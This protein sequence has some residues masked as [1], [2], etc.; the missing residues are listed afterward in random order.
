MARYASA[1]HSRYGGMQAAVDEAETAKQKLL[2]AIHSLESE[3]SG[4]RATTEE[5]KTYRGKWLGYKQREPEIRKFLETFA[6]VAKSVVRVILRAGNTDNVSENLRLRED[7]RLLGGEPTPI[8]TSRGAATYYDPAERRESLLPPQTPLTVHV[9]GPSATAT[10]ISLPPAT[11]LSRSGVLNVPTLSHGNGIHQ[12]HPSR[13]RK[14]EEDPHAN[15]EPF[16]YSQVEASLMPPPPLPPNRSSTA[17]MLRRPSQ[18]QRSSTATE[19]SLTPSVARTAKFLT[20]LPGS[21]SHTNAPGTGNSAKNR[22]NDFTPSQPLSNENHSTG[23]MSMF[24]GYG[25]RPGTSIP[26]HAPVG[27]VRSDEL[28]GSTMDRFLQIDSSTYTVPESTWGNLNTASFSIRTPS[29]WQEYDD[30][31]QVRMPDSKSAYR[32]RDDRDA[33]KM[34]NNTL[35]HAGP[36][37]SSFDPMT[38]QLSGYPGAQFAWESRLSPR[39]RQPKS[40]LNSL[41]FIKQPYTSRNEPIAQARPPDFHFSQVNPNPGP[42]TSSW[43]R[44]EGGPYTSQPHLNSAAVWASEIPER[45]VFRPI[46]PQTALKRAPHSTPLTA[47]DPRFP[48]SHGHSPP[49]YTSAPNIGGL[50][51]GAKSSRQISR[52]WRTQPRQYFR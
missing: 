43:A 36:I 38:R 11:G 27:A 50:S 51:K 7:I 14:L 30:H 45:P 20:A 28:K 29:R 1:M 44:L 24:Y 41:S 47:H 25:S 2:L 4:L 22:L 32:V 19:D 33:F 21:R 37:E 52:P 40:I 6:K 31:D 48:I 13:K 15:I 26:S 49:V 3:V 12:S 46:A 23:S 18:F 9:N 39:D 17:Q 5:L 10:D 8:N 16:A 42:P 35:P 34:E